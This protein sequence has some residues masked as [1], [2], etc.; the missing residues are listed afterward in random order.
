[1]LCVGT[2]A[3]GSASSIADSGQLLVFRLKLIA[4]YERKAP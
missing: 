2:L 4:A 1:M 3:G